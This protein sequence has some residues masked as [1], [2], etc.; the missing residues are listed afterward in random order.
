MNSSKKIIAI[1]GAES[2]G[3]STLA[4]ALSKH[5]DVP[6]V[7]EYA[8]DYIIN[9]GGKYT[10]ADVELIAR[11]QLEQYRNLIETDYPVII[12]DT[13]LLITK[14]WFE[15][16]FG[17]MPHWIEKEIHSH[18]IDLFLVCDTDL[19]WVADNVRE[20]GGENRI[21]LQQT[22][23]R[24]IRE[25]NFPFGVVSGTGDERIKNAIRLIEGIPAYPSTKH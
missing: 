21:K 25:H 23:I 5:Y 9:L 2:T 22:Y 7:P 19:P 18:R 13:W 17:K 16:V 24:E 10:F 3:K 6:F 15:V 1:T 4:E 14:I 8:R 12:L 11:K 20:N